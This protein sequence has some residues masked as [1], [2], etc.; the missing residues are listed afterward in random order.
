MHR[1]MTCFVKDVPRMNELT[2]IYKH[3]AGFDIKP[4]ELRLPV[5][6]TGVRL[7]SYRSDKAR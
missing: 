2:L 6:R 3:G 7:N 4:G 1:D 5:D